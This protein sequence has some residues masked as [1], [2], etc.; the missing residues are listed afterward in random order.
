LSALTHLPL[1]Q[2]VS[3]THRHTARAELNTGA[4]ER[5]VGQVTPPLAVHG[6]ELGAG[7]QP[8]PSSVP[9]PVQPEQLPLCEL[10]MQRPL[11]HAESAV[12]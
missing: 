12:Q 9:V 6:T 5:L 11:S 2:L 4:G 3:A 10:G 8:C 7:M 1:E